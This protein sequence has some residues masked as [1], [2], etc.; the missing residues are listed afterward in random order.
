ME[1]AEG[2]SQD[3]VTILEGRNGEIEGAVWEGVIYG[4]YYKAT[5]R[6]GEEPTVEVVEQ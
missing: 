4:K 2:E 3:G 6:L 5:Y 1:E